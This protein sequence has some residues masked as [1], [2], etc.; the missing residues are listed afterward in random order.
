MKR[1]LL[2]L[3][4]TALVVALSVSCASLAADRDNVNLALV[5]VVSSL[6]PTTTS[7]TVDLEVFHQIY[8]PLMYIDD[9]S[10]PH[11]R[12]AT[13]YTV[14][15]DGLVYTFTIRDDGF[16][17]NGDPITAED[18]VFTYERSMESGVL[19]P[20]VNMIEKVEKVGDNQVAMTLK[21]PYTP[22]INNTANVFIFSKRA[23]EEAGETF[24]ST[25]TGAGTGP[26]KV[27]AY[28]G[29]TRVDLE[30]FDK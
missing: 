21:Q 20:Y 26:Y 3:L 19:A 28:D 22:F 17:H 13:D 5:G 15:D 1:K 29:N 9:F 18:V 10:V 23:Y 4:F 27:V 11:A 2:F 8:E 24:G 14:S 12:V 16:F 25:I 30:A 6:D 7:L